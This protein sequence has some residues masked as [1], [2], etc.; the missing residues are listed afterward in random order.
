MNGKIAG[1]VACS[2]LIVGLTG[3][4]L[5]LKNEDKNS[6]LDSDVESS[7][8]DVDTDDEHDDE[9]LLIDT[10]STNIDNIVVTNKYGEYTFYKP[11]SGK[12]SWK[13]KELDGINLTSNLLS[14]L[15]ENVAQ[16]E[17]YKT[18]EENASDL[19]KYGLD[20][21]EGQFTVTF[22]NGETC[23][24]L[25]GNTS[26]KE[27]YRY[28]C[29]SGKNDVYMILESRVS[30][31]I[32]PK[33][34]FISTTLIA[35]PDTSD[36]P[37]YGK[38]VVKRKDLDYTL[39]FENDP[40]DRED[41]V[42][43][44]V[45]T[46]PIFAYLN[47]S[48]STDVTHGLWGLTASSA[49]QIFP[50][51]E[52]FKKYGLDKPSTTVTLKGDGYDYKLLIGNSI[53]TKDDEGNDTTE[54]G[55]Y[56]CYLTGVDGVDC[57]Y[58]ISAANLPWATVEPGDLVTNM[59]TTNNIMDVSQIKVKSDDVDVTFDIKSDGE[60]VIDSVKLNDKDVVVSDFQDL[61]RY[62]LTCPTGEVYFDEPNGE[63]TM[64]ID[65]VCSDGTTDKIEFF[66]DSSRRLVVKLNGRTS[67]RIQSKWVDQFV[68][69]IENLENGKSIVS[70]Y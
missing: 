34:N 29:E 51:D 3:A 9:K 24:F 40:Y 20:E 36:E 21:P 68:K 15:A 57:I 28:I 2:V 6:V 1:I 52:D 50:T 25:V 19:A 43:A 64:T 56:Y 42:S 47:V 5:V 65:I 66:K 44:Q 46:E 60:K 48:V 38:M 30:Y 41:M 35:T 4:L 58:E 67:F 49:V 17:T 63:S 22:R 45:M 23:T 70:T 32:E 31:F 13:I 18:V 61:Y 33:E 54:I 26:T 27:R 12:E 8:V 39:E 62:L 37:E 53:M 14:G 69:N 59:M 7:A 11:T 55:S 10:T 16:F